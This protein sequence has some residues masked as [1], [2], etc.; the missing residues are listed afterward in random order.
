MLINSFLFMDREEIFNNFIKTLTLLVKLS[1]YV[2]DNFFL[3]R[4]NGRITNLISVFMNYSIVLTSNVAQS[5]VLYNSL[6]VSIDGL[7]EFNQD[8]RH[9]N[10]LE[11]SLL[12]FEVNK[13]LLLTKLDVIKNRKLLQNLEISENK[14]ATLGKTIV[15]N[16]IFQKPS[17]LNPSKQKILNFIKSYP[18]TRT[19]D[20]IK[21]FSALSDRTVKRNLTEL[22]KTGIIKKRIDM[23]AT[24]YSHTDS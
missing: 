12:F 6:L 18:D 1:N 23:K 17:K 21:E 10:L 9:L 2:E 8:M 4:L 20:I 11:P 15:S 14:K 24:Y 19:K 7:I 22:L 16:K 3:D 13:Y 5:Q